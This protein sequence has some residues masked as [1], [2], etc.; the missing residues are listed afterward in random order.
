MNTSCSST[1]QKWFKKRFENIF[2]SAR[3]T[4]ALEA[5]RKLKKARLDNAKDYKRD[6]NVLTAHT[7]TAEEIRDKIERMQ[8]RLQEVAEEGE[9]ADGK[10]ARAQETLKELQQLQEKLRCFHLQL[11]IR[12]EDVATKEQ[13]VRS[14]YN[15]IEKIMSD[16]DEEL[17]SCLNN[18]DA[19]IE[20]H[21]TN[22][23]Y[24]ALRNEKTR[25]ET[26][27]GMY[28]K[29][30]ADLIDT[31]SKLSTKYRFHLQPLTSQ[32][33]DISSFLAEFRSVVKDSKKR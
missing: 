30:V 13:S 11:E 20:N 16:T 7:K 33:E 10:I 32:Q 6:L 8:E 2:E 15:K 19:T 17:Q 12:Q 31:A 18:Y 4:K 25:V 1:Q 5:I 22:E 27:I 14:A 26:N 28:Q 29:M 24:V 23:E 21:R 9:E 3:Y